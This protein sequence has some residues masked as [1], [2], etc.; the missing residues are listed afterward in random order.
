MV[1]MW[2]LEWALGAPR[3]YPQCE[4]ARPGACA[5]GSWSGYC[6]RDVRTDSQ[7]SMEATC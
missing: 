7:L 3:D 4:A 6:L 5:G 1:M 2:S